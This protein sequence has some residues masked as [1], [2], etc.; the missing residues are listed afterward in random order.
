MSIAVRTG[1]SGG[2]YS[3]ATL[4]SARRRGVGTAVTWAA[5]DAIREWGCTAAV[6]QSSEMGYPV[7]RAMGFAE[8]TRY[9]R[10]LPIAD[11]GSPLNRW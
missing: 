7:Y 2:I 8:V 9:T 4:E 5:V 10:Y 1:E 6:L 11:D 3:V